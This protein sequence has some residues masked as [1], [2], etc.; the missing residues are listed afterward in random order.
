LLDEIGF[1][2]VIGQGAEEGDAEVDVVE[3][4]SDEVAVVE[5]DVVEVGSLDVVVV[6]A[7]LVVDVVEPES[8]AGVLV[9]L[10]VEVGPLEVVD[11]DAGEEL[12]VVVVA[13]EGV[14]VEVDEVEVVEDDDVVR[15]PAA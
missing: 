3:V 8:L 14:V 9:E 13:T 1:A 6:E 11:V 2:P 7:E 4:G 15:G 10:V 5:L 12:E